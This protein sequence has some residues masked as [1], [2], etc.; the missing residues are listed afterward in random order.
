MTLLLLQQ[1]CTTGKDGKIM[2][3]KKEKTWKKVFSTYLK[4]CKVLVNM[5]PSIQN[6]YPTG[7]NFKENLPFL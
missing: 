5:L 1:L 6:S 4:V 3:D 2:S 7:K